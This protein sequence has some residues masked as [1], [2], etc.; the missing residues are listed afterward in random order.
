MHALALSVALALTCSAS[1]QSLIPTD[2]SKW[3]T[4]V[5]DSRYV[6]IGKRP[7]A[8][9]WH[10]KKNAQTSW[11]GCY[12]RFSVAKSSAYLLSLKAQCCVTGHESFPF[13]IHRIDAQGKRSGTAF[14]ATLNPKL[15]DLLT[16]WQ[17][18][19]TAGTYE[20]EVKSTTRN[21]PDDVALFYGGKLTVARL[22]L[23]TF[24]ASWE[25]A[26]EVSYEIHPQL[27]GFALL[28]MS[29]RRFASGIRI[30]GIDGELWL[31]SPLLA[32]VEK[33][34]YR[35]SFH[36]VDI[37]FDVVT[38]GVFWQVLEFEPKS[39]KLRLGSRNYSS[40]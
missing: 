13:T 23:V 21:I 26:K 8:V 22:P 4:V 32:A 9:W 38:S 12:V 31:P 35:R 39:Q 25:Q 37:W 34:R 10:P 3:T 15:D 18:G 27:G 30:P 6:E 5:G 2:M 7:S 17:L 24:R 40:R 19:L 29:R 28:Y 33:D 1:A 14:Q 36:G 11:G 20:L 16:H